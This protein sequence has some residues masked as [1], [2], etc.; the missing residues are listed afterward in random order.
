MLPVST[1]ETERLHLRPVAEADFAAIHAILG[2]PAVMYA[3]EHGFTEEETRQWIGNCL[4]RYERDGYSHFAVVRKETNRLIGLVGPLK[5]TLE[6]KTYV[7]LGWLL[8]RDHWKRGFA[9]EAAQ[10]SLRYTFDVIGAKTVIADIRPENAASIRLAQRLGMTAR[11]TVTKHYHGKD[12]P[13]TV[14]AAERK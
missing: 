4:A 3:W 2:D 14:Y 6:G 11:H 1:L 7:G 10:V 13:H 9:L 5:E 8:R 12:M